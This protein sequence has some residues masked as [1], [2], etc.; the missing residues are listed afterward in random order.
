V[1]IKEWLETVYPNLGPAE[2]PIE[3]TQRGGDIIFV[4]SWY[5]HGTLTLK[6]SVGV[7]VELGVFTPFIGRFP[8]LKP[9]SD[10]SK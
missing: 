1:P 6:E 2:K 9:W 10:T 8:F 3:C 7:A 4:P 5:G